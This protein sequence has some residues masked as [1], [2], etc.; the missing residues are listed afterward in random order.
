MPFST[1]DPLNPFVLDKAKA[2]KTANSVG[3]TQS[4]SPIKPTSNLT[5]R[6]AIAQKDLTAN[7]AI[8]SPKPRFEITTEQM[9]KLI[10]RFRLRSMTFEQLK[11]IPLSQLN[12]VEKDF[13]AYLRKNPGMFAKIANNKPAI[14]MEDIQAVSQVAKNPK[15]LT[16]Q[17]LQAL[18]ATPLEPLQNQPAPDAFL[19][20]A[21]NLKTQ[22]LID[23]LH[24][25][26][27]QG[28]TFDQL[29]NLQAEELALQEKELQSLR[30]LQST[31]ISKVLEKLVTPYDNQ[32]SPGVLRVLSSLV[33]NPAVVGTTPI[34]FFQTAPLA[35]ESDAEPIAQISPSG[36]SSITR[37]KRRT[38]ADSNRTSCTGSTSVGYHLHTSHF[39]SN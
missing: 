21:Q 3:L 39:T 32:L 31:T 36:G 2:V 33:W 38:A 23:T 37:I 4:S 30:F 27:P 6:S 15:V 20:N 19:A 25:I 14:T 35:L 16:D 9:I 7:P 10:M 34:V 24:Q 22:D 5:V 18:Q 1:I 17:D 26:S 8:G 12:Q 11:S 28:L 29:M 13:V